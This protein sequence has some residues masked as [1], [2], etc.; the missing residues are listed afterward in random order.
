MARRL[1]HPSLLQIFLEQEL[2][3]GTQRDRPN[4]M[5]LTPESWQRHSALRS[6]DAIDCGWHSRVKQKG[7]IFSGKIVIFNDMQ[8]KMR[9]YSIYMWEI[10]IDNWLYF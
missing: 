8:S 10:I 7:F 6:T 5:F 2:D 9:T 1:K 4:E 3:F